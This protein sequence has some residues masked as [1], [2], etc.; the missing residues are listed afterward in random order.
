MSKF[1]LFVCL[2]SAALFGFTCASSTVH[3]Y[4][5][6]LA[7][8]NRRRKL[9]NAYQKRDTVDGQKKMNDEVVKRDS[10]PTFAIAQD[11]SSQSGATTATVLESLLAFLTKGNRPVANRAAEVISTIAKKEFIVWRRDIE[12]IFKDN[13]INQDHYAFF[14]SIFESPKNY[15]EVV[16]GIVLAMVPQNNNSLMGHPDMY[17]LIDN[18]E[19]INGS[20]LELGQR[21]MALRNSFTYSGNFPPSLVI[22][23]IAAA[24]AVSTGEATSPQNIP[25][26]LS[27]LQ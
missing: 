27:S 12:Y 10:T 9:S 21:L 23:V 8:G 17:W 19:L 20:S 6:G 4:K 25:D 14:D 13:P 11:E 26:L 24:V 1:L 2:L 15:R 18:D 22:E 3:A 5:P 16:I 7:H